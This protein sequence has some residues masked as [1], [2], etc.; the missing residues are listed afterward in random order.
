MKIFLSPNFYIYKNG[1]SPL[2]V[3]LHWQNSPKGVL[4]EREKALVI[5]LFYF[6]TLQ[7]MYLVRS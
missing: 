4:L 7:K 3:V 1:T 5:S 2:V 6:V